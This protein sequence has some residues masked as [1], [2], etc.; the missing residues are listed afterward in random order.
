MS[1]ARLIVQKIRDG[2]PAPIASAA[3]KS[4]HAWGSAT[5]FG[6]M[7][8]SFI[9]VGAQRSG[10][11]SLFRLLSA[12]PQVVRPTLSKGTAYF[13]LNYDKGWRWYL[14]HFP[15]RRLS[16]LARRTSSVITFESC[17]YYMFHPLSP[18]RI[19]ADLPGVKIVAMLRNPTDRAHSAHRHEQ[20]R[21]FED[22]DFEEAIEQEPARTQDEADRIRADPTY[23]SF[24]LQHHAYLGR[25]QYA[26]QL[27]HL[28]DTFGV[29]NVCIVDADRFFDDTATEFTK[30]CR[31]LGL[32]DPMDVDPRAWN[33]APRAPMDPELRRRLDAH[34][35]PHDARLSEILGRVPSWRSGEM[36]LLQEG[37]D[38]I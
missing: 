21:G 19:A 33:A 16:M 20:R 14:G 24:E 29:S 1:R 26:E 23:S 6:R 22:L 28:I 4:A 27:E 11:T 10:T 30:L 34:F 25:G 38:P 7:K 37:N 13:D 18:S 15:L 36:S 5:A 3:R 9:I 31:W 32:Q 12:H 35:A 17:G 8:P 2:M